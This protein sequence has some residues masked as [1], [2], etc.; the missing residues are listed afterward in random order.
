[1]TDAYIRRLCLSLHIMVRVASKYTT[2]AR[3]TGSFTPG[4]R[5]IYEKRKNYCH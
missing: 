2:H 5:S 4:E 1:M 3:V